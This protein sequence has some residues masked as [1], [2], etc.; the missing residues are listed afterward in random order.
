MI[1]R[2]ANLLAISLCYA[3]MTAVATAQQ[4]PLPAFSLETDIFVAQDNKPVYRTVTLFRDGTAYDIPRDNSFISVV[5]SHGNRMT[6]VDATRKVQTQVSLAD[7]WRLTEDAKL[8]PPEWLATIIT[9]A[10]KTSASE[11]KIS[12]GGTILRYDATLQ[13]AP[14]QASAEAYAVFADALARLNASREP[15]AVPFARLHLNKL[16]SARTA[17]PL[18]VTKVMSP[19]K[20]NSVTRSVV[21]ADWKLTTENEQQIAAVRS[22]IDSFQPVSQSEFFLNPLQTA[23][24]AQSTK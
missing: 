20:S 2:L 6:L 8:S 9:D 18:E 21:H 14:N 1:L 15:S 11:K 23:A 19:G 22:M 16:I 17:L 3:S 24:R 7:L 12:V 13:A 5:D 10:E 4:A